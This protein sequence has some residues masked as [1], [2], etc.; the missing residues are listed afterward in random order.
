MLGK[1]DT[2]SLATP[3]ITLK[4]IINASVVIGG[5]VQENYY[6]SPYPVITVGNMTG[7]EFKFETT[8]TAV[9]A[10]VQSQKVKT[11][12]ISYKGVSTS[13]DASDF[14]LVEDADTLS[15]VLSSGYVAEAIEVA[16]DNNSKNPI[17]YSITIKPCIDATGAEPTIT[18]TFSAGS[19]GGGS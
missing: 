9:V 14:D 6:E 7:T 11:V 5:E 10:L 13:I 18:K 3:A 12:T 16:G 8:D 4:N 2:V 15:Y 1:V 17:T 19:G